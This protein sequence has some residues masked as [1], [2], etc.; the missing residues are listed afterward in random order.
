VRDPGTGYLVDPATGREFDP[1]TGRWIDPVTGK[2]FGDVVQYASRLEGLSGGTGV[3]V[4]AAG[5]GGGGVGYAPLF[6]G[7]GLTGASVAGMYGGAVPPSLMGNNPAS[8]QLRATAAN[9]MAAKAYAASQLGAREAAAGGRPFVPPM[10]AGGHGVAA[11]RGGAS[12]NPRTRMLIESAQTWTAG[13]RAPARDIGAGSRAGGGQAGAHPFVPPTTGG[14]PATSSTRNRPDWLVEDDVW[15]DGA[16]ATGG[17][18]GE[19]K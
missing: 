19:E 1:V 7:G 5:G 2:P 9:E 14:A 10:Q 12:R 15:S 6:G 16:Q 11:A 13:N 18:L 4:L 3:G 17:V 8:A